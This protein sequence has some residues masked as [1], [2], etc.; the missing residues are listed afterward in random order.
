MSDERKDGG[1][2]FPVPH[3]ID[4]NWVP[5]PRPEYSGMSLRDYFAGEALKGIA[6]SDPEAVTGSSS[7]TTSD[8]ALERESV[9]W[10]CYAMADAMLKARDE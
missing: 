7:R 2:A 10:S 5:D 6:I 1:P 3:N 8:D 4:G 9:A